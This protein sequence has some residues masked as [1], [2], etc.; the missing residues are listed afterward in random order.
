MLRRFFRIVIRGLFQILTRFEVQGLDHIPPEGG[1]LIAVNHLSRLDPPAIFAVIE[2]D[3]LSALVADKYKSHL[4]IRPVVEYVKGIWIHREDTDFRALRQAT[5]YL[6]NGGILGI[7]PEG[8]RSSSRG[9]ITAKTGVAYLADK[10]GA[11][12]IPVAIAGTDQIFQAWGKLRRPKVV[13]RFGEPFRLPPLDRKNRVAQLQEN[14]AE[15]MLRIAAMLPEEY[16]GV[17]ADDPRL[18]AYPS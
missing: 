13:L 8:T 17:Y 5:E 10:A 2:R 4:L 3:D 1:A 6:Q 7:A 15:I 9:L 12:V 11:P 14:T 16:R 18:K